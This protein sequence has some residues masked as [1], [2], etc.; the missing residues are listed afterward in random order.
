MRHRPLVPVFAA[1][2]LLISMLRFMELPL[3]SLEHFTEA[4]QSEM[5]R[6]RTLTGTIAERWRADDGYTYLLKNVSVTC[7]KNS[8]VISKARMSGIGDRLKTGTVISAGGKISFYEHE[9]NPGGF[10]KK[11]YYEAEGI[12]CTVVPRN[13]KITGYRKI[14]GFTEK[15]TAFRERLSDIF[16]EAMGEENG[17]IL[18]AMLLG[19]KEGMEEETKLNY[20]ASGL[21][22]LLAISGLHVGIVGMAL[23]RLL[24]FLRMK[25]APASVLASAVLYVYCIFTGSHDSTLRAF[26]MFAILAGARCLLRSYDMPSSLSLAGI[27]LLT[28][29]PQRLF[30]AG[31]LLSFGAAGGLAFVFP[32]LS[33]TFPFPKRRIRSERVSKLLKA[34]HEGLLVWLGVN[35]ATI[36]ILLRFYYEFAVYGVLANILFVPMT[37]AVLLFGIAGGLLSVFFL[38]PGKL[39]LLIPKYLI[40]LQDGAGKVIRHLPGN[41]LI[42][43]KPDAL[44]IICYILGLAVLLAWFAICVNK[45]KR[46]PVLICA[47]L[48]MGLIFIRPSYDFSVT[49]LDVGQGDCFAI[50]DGAG[51]TMLV[52]GGSSSADRCGK[53]IILP[54]L[55]AKGISRLAGVFVTHNDADHMNG[56]LEMLNMKSDRTSSIPIETLFLPAW[57]EEDETGIKLAS[58]AGRAGTKVVYLSAGAQILSEKTAF[59]VIFPFDDDSYTGNEGSLVMKLRYQ[60][61]TALFTGDLEGEAEE[62]VTK[63]VDHCDYLKVA[64]HGSGGSSSD[65]FLEAVSPAVCIIS[66]PKVSIYNHPSPETIRRI[67]K[68][69]S[70]WLQTGKCGA[71][72]AFVRNNSILLDTYRKEERA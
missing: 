44:R 5:S 59:R 39:L 71:I 41:T 15:M 37:T 36:P 57:M 6:I 16:S 22:H 26:L 14:Y 53:Y 65:T 20:S 8:Y 2:L 64:H 34:G 46:I 56:I 48:L 7:A 35:L 61:F 32:V 10:D 19:E 9:S 70:Q 12:V 52:D 11:T 72:T 67:E 23:L 30:A 69:G 55:K 58:A 21:G 49:A 31:F 3:W 51:H 38:L 13:L 25:R 66:A 24:L 29:R 40:T 47:V 42:T 28:L 27:I 4:E 62:I 50:T 43:G 33:R 45:K 17:P 1:L 54:Y 60:D 18:S 68:A 63:L